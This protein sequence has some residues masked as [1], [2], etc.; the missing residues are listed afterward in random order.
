MRQKIKRLVDWCCT[1]AVAVPA[2]MCAIEA[3]FNQTSDVVFSFWAQSFAML[4]GLPG[5]SLRRAFYKLTLDECA[6]SFF[7]GFGAMFAHR[8]SRIEQDAYI[9]PYAVIGSAWLLNLLPLRLG[10]VGRS[11]DAT[12][13]RGGWSSVAGFVIPHERSEC[14]DLLYINYRQP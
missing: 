1:A 7:I 2:A 10:M 9:G 12:T 6:N 14:R 11:R 4:P 5:V 8:H 13:V 3:A